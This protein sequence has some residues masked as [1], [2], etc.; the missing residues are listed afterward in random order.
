[1]DNYDKTENGILSSNIKEHLVLKRSPVAI[2][3]FLDEKT[4][5]KEIPRIGKDLRHCEMV[6]MAVSGEIFYATSKEQQACKGGAGAIGL[7]ELPEPIKT[8]EMYLSLGKFSSL[9][10]AKRTVD[11]I[12]KIDPVMEAV[13][14]SPLEKAPYNPD[15]VL[16]ICSPLQ[17]MQ[18]SQALLYRMGGRLNANFGGIQS[19]CAD[20]TAGPYTTGK[21]N[22]TLGCSGSRKF[23]KVKPDELII[24]MNGEDIGSL[25]KALEER[26]A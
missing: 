3:F 15:V 24:G 12:P 11:A 8:G 14:Y 23:A 19:I 4:I 25:V 10:A 22:V 16:L 18:L 9:G 26:E 20:T 13:A 2:K 6:Q 1:M 7:M 5:P 21:A 17:A